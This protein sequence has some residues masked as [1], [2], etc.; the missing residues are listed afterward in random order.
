MNIFNKADE[1]TRRRFVA[2]AASS[3]LGVNYLTNFSHADEK[4][5]PSVKGTAKSVIYLYMSGGMSHLDTFDIK[6]DNSEVRGDAGAIETNVKGIRV[7]KFLPKVAKQMDKIAIVNSLTTTQG[8]H[9]EGRYIMHTSYERRGTIQHPEMGAW[10]TKLGGKISKTLPSFVKVGGGGRSLGGGFFEPSYAALPVGDPKS[11]LQYSTRHRTVDEKTFN[12]RMAML[13]QI[14]GEFQNNFKQSSVKSYNAMYEDAVKLMTSEDLKAF[15]IS[16]EPAENAARYGDSNFG[17]GCLLAR[18]LVEKGVRFVEV[19]LGGWDNHSNIYDKFAERTGTLD[20]ALAALLQ[21]LAANGLLD[22]T[23]VVLATEFG[24][25]PKINQNKGRDHYPKAFSGILA[26]G[27]IKGGQV[28]GKTDAGGMNVVENKV[29]VEDFNAT[30]ATAL[31]LPINQ[32]LHS[33]TGR[34]FQ[35]AHKGKPVLDLF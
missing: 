6:P 23:L 2:G 17:Q 5:T 13:K 10:V 34:P 3:M 15:D 14:N 22:S 33:P 25:T 20:T 4:N 12:D 27:G 11:G 18:R 21:D 32:I 28:Y 31:G 9:E 29:K 24:R 19:N 8:A 35:V 16:K 7:S 1:I 30:I 26:G